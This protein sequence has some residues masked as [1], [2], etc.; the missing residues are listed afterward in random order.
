MVFDLFVLGEDTHTENIS[1]IKNIYSQAYHISPIYDSEA[2][3]LLDREQE[4]IEKLT[5]TY[6]FQAIK[7]ASENICP[8]IA[9]IPEVGMNVTGEEIYKYTFLQYIE[10]DEI[11]DFA[12]RCCQVLNIKNAINEVEEQIGVALPEEVK[13]CAI[14]SFNNRIQELE[15]VMEIRYEFLEVDDYEKF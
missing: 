3:L 13:L 12:R 1:Y 8:R 2:S 10:D 15:K 4:T 9:L 14:I 7:K 11:E 5:N 6:G